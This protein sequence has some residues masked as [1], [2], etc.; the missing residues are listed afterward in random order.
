M[1]LQFSNNLSPPSYNNI[2]F[3][4]YAAVRILEKSGIWISQM[5]RFF[6]NYQPL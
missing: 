6:L 5:H 4:Y 1:Y 2:N 3:M